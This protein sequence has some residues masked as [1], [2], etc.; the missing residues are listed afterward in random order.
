MF[1]K[2]WELWIFFVWL[3]MMSVK[4]FCLDSKVYHRHPESFKAWTREAGDKLLV[5][6][7]EQSFKCQV[8]RHGVKTQIFYI[9]N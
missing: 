5:K 2:V 6:E 9:W 1:K 4:D 8:R 7:W 3:L